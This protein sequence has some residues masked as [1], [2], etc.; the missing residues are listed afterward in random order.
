[1]DLKLIILDSS[2][3]IASVA[4]VGNLGPIVICLFLWIK[5]EMKHLISKTTHLCWFEQTVLRN[6]GTIEGKT[7]IKYHFSIFGGKIILAF[8]KKGEILS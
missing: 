8:W 4:K 5:S 7:L 6:S 2:I 3:S 1:M